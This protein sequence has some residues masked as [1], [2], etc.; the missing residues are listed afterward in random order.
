MERIILEEERVALS[1]GVYSFDR[2]GTDISADIK[3]RC[4]YSI[5]LPKHHFLSFKLNL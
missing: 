1:F 2:D 5:T 4:I 3:L